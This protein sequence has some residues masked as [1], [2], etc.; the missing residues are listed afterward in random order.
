MKSPYLLLALALLCG[1]STSSDPREGGLVGYWSTGRQGY[2][3]RLDERGQTLEGIQR[4][5]AEEERAGQSA[6]AR[7]QSLRE[8]LAQQR[9]RLQE[10]EDQVEALLD[11]SE[12]LNLETLAKQE[13]RA[14]LSN[15]LRALRSRVNAA[16]KDPEIR[17]AE[18]EREL[19]KLQ[20]EVGLLL[21]RYSLLT[22]L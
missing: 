21:E 20:E 5:T 10:I 14:Q 6:A 18:R 11:E 3:Q 2:Q 22:T 9:A 16:Q 17:I 19:E 8:Q 15:D 13:E 12:A 7:R 4:Q 1:C